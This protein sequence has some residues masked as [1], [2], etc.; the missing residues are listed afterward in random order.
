MENLINN[1]TKFT[2][3]QIHEELYHIQKDLNW[4]DDSIALTN[5]QRQLYNDIK[6]RVKKV[7]GQRQY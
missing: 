2:I 7:L 6:N 3:E 5:D 1:V 4:L